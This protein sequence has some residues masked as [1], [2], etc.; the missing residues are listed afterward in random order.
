MPP[1]IVILL[2]VTSWDGNSIT[3]PNR[4]QWADL[5]PEERKRRATL[6]KRRDALA[7]RQK[8]LAALQASITARSL[9]APMLPVVF[10][11]SQIQAK[12]CCAFSA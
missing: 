9:L 12:P 7:A 11:K 2:H 1:D 6:S 4:L 5:P 8:E 10:T 3:S